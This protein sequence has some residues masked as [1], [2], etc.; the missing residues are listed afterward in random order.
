[1]GRGSLFADYDGNVRLRKVVTDHRDAYA[2][3]S[4][5]KDKQQIV[6]SIIEAVQALGGRFLR[7]VEL[8]KEQKKAQKNSTS[9]SYMWT[10]VEDEKLVIDKVKQ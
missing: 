6:R 3:S 10:V 5:H 8:S 1:M 2:S 7:R 4:K 9:P